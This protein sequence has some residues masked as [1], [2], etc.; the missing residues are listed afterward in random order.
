MLDL[1]ALSLPDLFR[2]LTADGLFGRTLEIARQEDLG[3]AGDITSGSIIPPDA[4]AAASLGV[5]RPGVIAGLA[6]LPMLLDVFGLSLRA[7]IERP[8]G[9]RCAAGDVIAR[10]EGPLRGLLAVERTLLNLI[11][12]LSGIAT[13]TD[14]YVQQVRGTGA[15][16]CDTRKTTPG[17]RGVEKYA[18]RC[19]G[20]TLHRIGLY[21]AVLYKDNHLA[22]IPPVALTQAIDSAARAVREA[23][24]PRFVEVEVDSLA[25]LDAVLA[26]EEGLVDMILLDNMEPAQLREAVVRRDRSRRRVLLEASG[27]VSLTTVGAMAATG[28]DRISV[29]AITHSAPALDVGLDI[30]PP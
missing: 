2:T 13:L 15:V 10:L 11:G 20:G 3:G 6:A 14:A 18:V 9:S 16:V 5:R 1:N 7:T 23:A 25:Q 8:D 4:A 27:G 30:E 22:R 24:S 28:V 21:D 12:R 26:C 19:G 29:G 17:L